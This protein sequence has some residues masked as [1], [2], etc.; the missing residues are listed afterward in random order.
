MRVVGCD[1]LFEFAY[2]Q[3]RHL[4]LFNG[5][6]LTYAVVFLF[7]VKVVLL[8]LA[9]NVWSVAQTNDYPWFW[10]DNR[11][12]EL[13]FTILMHYYQFCA[14]LLER[15]EKNK[16]ETSYVLL[17]YELFPHWFV[18]WSSFSYILIE[19][20]FFCNVNSILIF[21]LVTIPLLWL[22]LSTHT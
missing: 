1:A 2:N 22:S 3:V 4:F 12:M 6:K 9:W 17:A 21:V 15:L 16:G 19:M 5:W 8:L 10:V 7:D 14:L 11:L 13:M 18:Q 20:I